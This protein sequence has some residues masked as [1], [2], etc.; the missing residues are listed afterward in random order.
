MLLR[1]SAATCLRF[2]D[3]RVPLSLRGNG[4]GGSQ[5]ATTLAI[6]DG[7]SSGSSTRGTERQESDLYRLL[8]EPDFYSA[9]PLA[10]TAG[11]G[12]GF[13]ASWAVTHRPPTSAREPCRLVL[14]Q[15][16]LVALAGCGGC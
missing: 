4:G 7:S 12:A 11:C 10:V 9:L 15:L 6:T 13:G 5:Q 3:H 8:S 14:S 16:V 1:R 2:Q